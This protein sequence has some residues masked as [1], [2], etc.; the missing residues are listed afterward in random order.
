MLERA[1]L[2]DHSA[3]AELVR[4]HQSMVF[5]IA[6]NFF[7]NDAIAEDLSQDVFVH[8]YRNIG[9]IQSDDHL[10]YWLRRVTS[11][12][13]IDY[14]RRGGLKNVGI[15]EVAELQSELSTPDAVELMKTAALRRMVS[16][17][18]EQ[19]RLMITLRY[20]EDM[21]PTEISEVLE[22]PLNTVKSQL[23]RSLLVLRDKITRR[24]GE[25]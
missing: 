5:S 13:C 23:R 11:H 12:R 16:S 25:L 20:Q 14:S 2:G 22:M 18:P 4:R 8:L 19:A 6:R 15:D 21:T 3:F 9:S 10:K 24:F 7:R 17:L 1:R